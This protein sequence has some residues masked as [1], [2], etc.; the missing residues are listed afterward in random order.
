MDF[1]RAYL[2]SDKT[3]ATGYLSEQLFRQGG[4]VDEG[5]K[6]SLVIKFEEMHDRAPIVYETTVTIVRKGPEDF[7]G[8]IVTREKGSGRMDI[9]SVW[10]VAEPEVMAGIEAL[11]DQAVTD[12]LPYDMTAAVKALEDSLG[13]PQK[14]HDADLVPGAYAPQDID[15]ALR[16]GKVLKLN[17]RNIDF[18]GPLNS[19][20]SRRYYQVMEDVE[21]FA[22]ECHRRLA[23][24]FGDKAYWDLGYVIAE[25]VKNGFVH[26]NKLDLDLPVYL[27]IDMKDRK[28]IVYDMDKPVMDLKDWE[29]RKLQAEN[30][31]I[32]GAFNDEQRSGTE[33]IRR[34]PGWSY[35]RGSVMNEGR[36]RNIGT[37]AE[38]AYS[39]TGAGSQIDKKL[40]G[41]LAAADFSE[42]GGID[43]T[44]ARMDLQ[45]GNDG[46]PVIFDIDPLLLQRLSDAAGVS[47]VIR[48]MHPLDD[49]AA[50]LGVPTPAVK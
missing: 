44:P 5:G 42:T 41:V 7:W 33:E 4:I 1:L 6:R 46:S 21:K 11:F 9:E 26:G 27:T 22:N 37:R 31:G 50:F 43:L 10:I 36:S 8:E 19:S 30:A 40:V 39:V 13:G 47:P 3:L 35:D 28:V 25:L 23:E 15:A 14:I 20:L 24:D 34:T 2:G 49:L 48:G 12:V 16:A 45:T 29:A 38:A 32:W 17:F 18:R